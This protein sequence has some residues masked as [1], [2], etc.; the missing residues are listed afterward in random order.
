M[1]LRLWWTWVC[2]SNLAYLNSSQNQMNILFL[3]LVNTPN[4]LSAKKTCSLY[5]MRLMWFSWVLYEPTPF[6][7]R[8]CCSPNSV[9]PTLDYVPNSV[10]NYTNK[11]NRDILE[12][13]CVW[14]F[15]TTPLEIT[16]FTTGIWHGYHKIVLFVTNL[17]CYYKTSKKSNNCK[18]LI[19]TF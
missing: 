3:I 2:M 8:K 16:Y 11:K 17:D 18:C 13:N 10:A 19:I 1:S 12:L 4:W 7:L 15:Q 5:L 9:F 14:S 6:Y